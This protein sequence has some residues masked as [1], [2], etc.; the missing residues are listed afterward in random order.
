[1]AITYKNDNRNSFLSNINKS[2]SPG[3]TLTIAVMCSSATSRRL[4]SWLSR[5]SFRAGSSR[6]WLSSSEHSSFTPWNHKYKLWARRQE[7]LGIPGAILVG[8]LSTPFCMSAVCLCVYE[9]HP[10]HTDLVFGTCFLHFTIDSK[11]LSELADIHPIF[12]SYCM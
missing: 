12:I 1:M 9:A 5:R 3:N 7:A 6:D 10:G 11:H 2:Q 8:S 4:S